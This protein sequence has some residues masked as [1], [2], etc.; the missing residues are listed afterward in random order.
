[1]WGTVE[2]VIDNKLYIVLDNNQ[3]IIINNISNL[4]IK[5]NNYI[6]IEDNEIVEVKEYNE[7]LYN[8]IK[9]LEK[10]VLKNKK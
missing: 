3:K 5:E 9:Q 8:K 1:M 7:E 10:K 4:H 2:Q 6:R